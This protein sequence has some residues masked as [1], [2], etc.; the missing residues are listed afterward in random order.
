MVKQTD[1]GGFGPLQDDGINFNGD[2]PSL[3]KPPCQDEK[4]NDANVRSLVLKEEPEKLPNTTTIIQKSD[5][6][7]KDLDDL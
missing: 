6:V 7:D 1:F 2:L 4:N 3:P 5:K